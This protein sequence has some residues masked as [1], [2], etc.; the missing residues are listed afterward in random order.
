MLRVALALLFSP[1]LLALV[2]A[3]APKEAEETKLF[4]PTKVGDKWTYL[5]TE[6]ANKDKEWEIVETVTAVEDK[7]GMKVVTVGR[8]EED[9][10]VYRN[11]IRTVSEK[12]VWQ[13]ES[14]ILDMKPFKTPW[15][16]L[17]LPHKPGQMW[18]TRTRTRA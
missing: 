7:K 1:P 8:V 15:V 18:T 10:K 11:R 6:K 17:K 13:M 4:F 14:S 12:G 9:G 2:A 5:F 3:P 16:H